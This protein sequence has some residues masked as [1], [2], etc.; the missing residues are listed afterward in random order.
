MQRLGPGAVLVFPWRLYAVWSFSG[1]R[2]VANPAGS[3]FTREV[4]ASRS[5][6]LQGNRDGAG[7]PAQTLIDGVLAHPGRTHD[8]GHLIAPLGVRYV[9]VL[10]EADFW[11]YG[12]VRHQ[13][14]L[15]LVYRSSRLALYESTV[16]WPLKRRRT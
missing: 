12:F 15:R 11:H 3:F 14:D 7:D 13:S 8:L 10:H 1:G 16:R 4:I 6:G 5:S 9:L 2:I